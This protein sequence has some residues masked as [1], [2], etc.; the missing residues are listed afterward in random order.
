MVQT[1]IYVIAGLAVVDFFRNPDIP[2]D[3]LTL[4]DIGMVLMIY[5]TLPIIR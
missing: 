2:F 4:S 5:F 3:K 1:L